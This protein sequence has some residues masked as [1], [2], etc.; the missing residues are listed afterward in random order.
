MESDVRIPLPTHHFSPPPKFLHKCISLSS[1]HKK[2][3]FD[4]DVPVG[5]QQDPLSLKERGQQ[6][7]LSELRTSAEEEAKA[8]KKRCQRVREQTK[9]QYQ[10]TIQLLELVAQVKEVSRRREGSSVVYHRNC[11]VD[12]APEASITL[13]QVNCMTR[14]APEGQK[15]GER[16]EGSK[17]QRKYKQ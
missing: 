2:N 15:M 16:L 5:M 8:Q 14:Q 3:Y 12:K 6:K 4:R 9:K 7:G 10:E 11:N 13:T 17:A 1:P